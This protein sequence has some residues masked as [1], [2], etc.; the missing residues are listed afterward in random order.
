[1][2]LAVIWWKMWRT[3]V[4]IS[5]KWAQQKRSRLYASAG[6]AEIRWPNKSFSL[7]PLIRPWLVSGGA[8]VSPT[9]HHHLLC[10][11]GLPAAAGCRAALRIGSPPPWWCRRSLL[12]PARKASS[13][14]RRSPRW[15]ILPVDEL[16]RRG[17]LWFPAVGFAPFLLR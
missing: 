4:R 2:F 16:K 17:E 11:G 10:S 6:R 14:Y 9:R 5:P 8:A 7:M 3:S 1:M 15:R 13:A 12:C